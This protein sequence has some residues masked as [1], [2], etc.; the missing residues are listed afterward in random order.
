MSDVTVWF[1]PSC[2]KC[3]QVMSLLGAQGV[4]ADVV[5]YLDDPPDAAEI[6]RVCGLLGI[7]PQ[8]LL[9]RDE[10]AW[11]ASGLTEDASGDEIIEAMARH[12]ALIQRPVVIRGDRAVIGRPPE[13]V[14]DLF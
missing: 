7:G 1:N 9:R 14:L 3:N 4:D 6:R 13:R 11:S 2:S 8:A 5:R 10:P 12:P